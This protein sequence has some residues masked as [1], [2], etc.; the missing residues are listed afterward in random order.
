ME[1]RIKALTCA[2]I[3]CKFINLIFKLIRAEISFYPY[4][5]ILKLEKMP[6]LAVLFVLILFS[7][8]TRA[9]Q[10]IAP[11]DRK[12]TTETRNLYYSMQRLTATGVMFGHHDDTAYGVN[13]RLQQDSSDVKDVCG[14]YP[15][16]Y[17]WDFAKME[18]DSTNDINGVPFQ[19]QRRLVQEAYQRGGINTFCWH[20]DNP[21]NDRS[22]WDTT[23]NSVKNILE[24]GANHDQYIQYLKRVADYIKTLK[25]ANGEQIPILFRPFHELTGGWFWWGNRTTDPQDFIQLWRE[26]ID[27]FRK[28]AKIHNLLIVYSTADF[29]SE[30]EFLQRYPGDDYADVIGFD[31]YCTNSIPDF[32]V[33]LDQ[34][35]S[36]LDKVAIDHHKV[37]AVP[38]TGY[39]GIPDANWWTG[40]LLPELSKYDRLS[41]V[42]TWRNANQ[43]HFFAP[44]PGQKSA[45]D[46][47][48]F[49]SSPKV[50]MQN[51]LTP[52]AIY[53]KQGV[54]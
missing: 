11:C 9:Q 3:S 18:H 44:Y 32:V 52:L 28:K 36:I 33:R 2:L 48:R 38:E 14:S 54:R 13:W 6:K 23:G 35:L 16:V 34:Q 30:E 37:A 26:T 8:L 24:G 45:A 1:I 22:A 42:L 12:A 21:V 47:V 25:G 39:Q 17:G 20:M 10:L 40:T 43:N 31:L 29:N 51:R 19:E 4:M 53:S 50:I 46:F 15:A 5:R 41:Y 7:H 27:Y 49:T